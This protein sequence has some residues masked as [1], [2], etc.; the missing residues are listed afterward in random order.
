MTPEKL[1]TKAE[2]TPAKAPEVKAPAIQEEPEVTVEKTT[3][4]KAGET[5]NADKEDTAKADDEAAVTA[6]SNDEAQ[7]QEPFRLER[8]KRPQQTLNVLG[9]IDLSA[10]NQSTRPKK[11]SKEE[12]KRAREEKA[13]QA[14][15]TQKKKRVR[16][17][18]ERV[19]PND[20]ANQPKKDKKKRG[21]QQGGQQAN[22]NEI[23]RAS[24]RERV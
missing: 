22:M 12:K 19:D 9:K 15:D 16:I 6:D 17:G 8:N 14:R 21:G 1:E 18:T 20:I 13:Q 10:L 24:C 11:K 4:T 5:E 2:E 3:E 7:T 23:G